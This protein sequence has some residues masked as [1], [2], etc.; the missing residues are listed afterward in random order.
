MFQNR[1]YNAATKW[2]AGILIV[3]GLLILLQQ[4]TGCLFPGKAIPFSIAETDQA[5]G[6]AFTVQSAVLRTYLRPRVHPRASV[7]ENGKQLPQRAETSERVKSTPGRYT[8]SSRRVWFSTADG[9]DPR[10]N[11][12]AYAAVF[13]APVGEEWI[14]IAWIMLL[15]GLILAEY[16]WRGPALAAESCL[17]T[18]SSRIHLAHLDGLRAIAAIYVVMHHASFQV[19][20]TNTGFPAAGDLIKEMLLHGRIAVD[21]FIVLSG[22]CLMLPVI[23]AVGSLRDGA[24]GFYK[25]RAW[26]ILPPYYFAT[27]ASLL[28]ISTLIHEK[29]GTHWDISIPVSR[30]SLL[31]HFLLVHDVFSDDFTINH[32]FWSI[33]V[34]WRIYLVFPLILLAWN[35]IGPIVT[36]VIT[37]MVSPLIAMACDRLIGSSLTANYLGL[38]ALGMLSASIAFNKIGRVQDLPW[39]GLMTGSAAG[40]IYLYVDPSFRPSGLMGEAIIDGLIGFT[41]MCLLIIC[42]KHEGGFLKKLVSMKPLVFIGTF[43]Y[44]I[45]LI[46][47]PLLQVLTQYVFPQFRSSPLTMLTLLLVPGIPLIIGI[48]YVFYIACEKPFMMVGKKKTAELD[49]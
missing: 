1:N 37:V 44:S 48:S 30:Q 38:F 15:G 6:R 8:F 33:A 43:S 26:R 12:R 36:T 49:N 3:V 9:S 11:G 4:T 29:T 18:T 20:L 46:H 47:A 25:R 34:E 24:L 31:T 14:V 10:T 22:F 7:T 17:R 5:D 2:G 19:D 28:L 41:S 35:Q 23:G 42:V 21:V 45:Y 32:A 40:V 16:A 27:L 39:R 13:P